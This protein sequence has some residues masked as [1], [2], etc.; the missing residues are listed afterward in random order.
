MAMNHT[1]PQYI[2][3]DRLIA[4]HKLYEDIRVKEIFISHASDG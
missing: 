2:A 3:P 4:V 1:N